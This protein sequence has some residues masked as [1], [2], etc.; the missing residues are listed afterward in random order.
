M[1]KLF[2]TIVK[3]TSISTCL[4]EDKKDIKC[5]DKTMCTLILI[6]T[7]IF[8]GPVFFP[9]ISV[10]FSSSNADFY[11]QLQLNEFINEA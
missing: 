7:C 6:L 5:L 9:F 3:I 11:L 1:N 4:R 10:T 2:R 8:L